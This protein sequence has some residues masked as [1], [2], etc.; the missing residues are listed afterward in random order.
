MTFSVIGAWALNNYG[1][2]LTV[3]GESF[4]GIDKAHLDTVVL[5]STPSEYTEVNDYAGWAE[6]YINPAVT[7]SSDKET[8]L[9]HMFEHWEHNY[10]LPIAAAGNYRVSVWVITNYYN[11]APE[12]WTLHLS[13]DGVSWSDVDSY[14]V[15]SFMNWDKLTGEIVASGSGYVWVSVTTGGVMDPLAAG[16]LFE[17]EDAGGTTYNQ[18]AGGTLGLA[19]APVRSTA[20]PIAGAMGLAGAPGRAIDKA[21]AGSIGFAGGIARTVGKLA[22]GT[23]NMGR[24]LQH[25]YFQYVL[26]TGTLP[27]AGGLQRHA[28]YTLAGTLGMVGQGV[29]ITY[30]QLAGVLPLAGHA[31]KSIL[32]PSLAGSL[33]M[34]GLVRR[35]LQVTKAGSIGFAGNPVKSATRFIGGSLS[36]SGV[37][38]QSQVILLTIAGVLGLSGLVSRQP[39]KITR[40]TMNMSGI[41]QRLPGKLTSGV[42]TPTGS[43]RRTTARQLIG[44]PLGLSGAAPKTP[45]KRLLGTV[46]LEGSINLTLA[47]F[48]AVVISG[49][50]HL[51]GGIRRDS[52]RTFKGFFT[53]TGVARKLTAAYPSGSVAFSGGFAGLQVGKALSGVLNASGGLLRQANIILR[54]ALALAGQPYKLIYLPPLMGT[55]GF[56]GDPVVDF[57]GAL[58]ELMLSGTVS[59]AGSLDRLP[60]LRMVGNLSFTKFVS[61]VPTIVP[62]MY[63]VLTTGALALGGAVTRDT[64]V[65]LRG[66]LTPFSGLTA[67]RKRIVVTVRAIAEELYRAT[68]R[69]STRYTIRSEEDDDA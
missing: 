20:K 55:I 60:K 32:K 28:S 27:L 62:K 31:A 58:V 3:D 46:T 38:T 19:G 35:A 53:P 21:L 29:H 47:D 43:I 67:L 65:T 17:K 42:L 10:K 40:G 50:L 49:I 26:A 22:Q 69:G 7:A 16:I 34:S 14:E 63:E 33:S 25:I 12:T 1:S 68:G 2:T 11:D 61:V 51:S 30:S 23:F 13:T 48:T 41:A 39:G 24:T 54:G 45:G 9:I 52:A 37:V 4:T 56:A 6:S 5:G 64:W 36:L 44:N 18:A 8:M 59:F 57:F 15:T 66:I